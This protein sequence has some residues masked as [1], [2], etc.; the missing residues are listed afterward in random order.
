MA[1][2]NL[3]LAITYQTVGITPLADV[4]EALQST[5][6][7]IRDAVS[8]LPSL[9]E[10]V[11]IERTQIN[12]RSLSQ[13]SPLRE[14]FLVS[15][16]VAFQGDLNKEIPP[17]LED[18][19]KVDIPDSYDSIVTVLTM[20]V[21]FYGAAF[22]KDASVKA[23]ENG[24]LRR[25]LNRLIGQIAQ[26]TGK[27]E[28]EVRAILDAKYSEPGPVKRLTKTIRGFFVPSQREGGVGIQFDREP[29]QPEVIRE[30]PI[31]E[32]Y[33]DRGDLERY[34]SFEAVELEIHAQ[35]RDRLNAGWAAVPKGIC[36][37][38]LKMKLMESVGAEDIW[39]KDTI[40]G[41][42][43]IVSKLTTS[44]YKPSEIHLTKLL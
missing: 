40:T 11:H 3:P 38:R 42:I 9:L 36:S 2:I 41:N 13:E 30:V 16:I 32:S 35:D 43:T 15:L 34:Q 20:I 37:S 12:V 39:T 44:G 18:I 1:E 17:M 29:I 7:A 21:L 28:E 4:I 23:V 6:T 25:Q 19:L 8:L 33:D 31:G 10:G 27:S 26:S 22:I 5:D 14:L 24:A